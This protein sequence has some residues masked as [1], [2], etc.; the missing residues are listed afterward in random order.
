MNFIVERSRR[1]QISYCLR[2]SAVAI[3]FF[4]TSCG[5]QTKLK[6]ASSV[7]GRTP[8]I[9][10]R[11]S[12]PREIEKLIYDEYKRWNGTR[13]RLGGTSRNGIDCSGFVR[14]VYKN[15]FNIELPRTTKAQVKKGTPV[16]RAELSA[17]D[18][19]FFR[20]PT[21]PRHV[22][23]FL[24]GKGFAHASKSKGVIISQIDSHYW[25]KHYWTARRILPKQ[26]QKNRWNREGPK[27]RGNQGIILMPLLAWFLLNIR[28]DSVF[29]ILQKII[30]FN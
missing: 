19:V 1:L 13:H 4:A 12:G 15:V 5:T 22:G 11:Y 7:E 10:K 16:K 17:G 30:V 29:P 27:G 25:G 21:Y 2:L 26:R 28:N 3:L 9:T 6:T 20:P 23:I 18:L 14:M 24:S 8:A